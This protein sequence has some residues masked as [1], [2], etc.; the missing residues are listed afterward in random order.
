MIM[1]KR[2]TKTSIVII[3]FVC[4]YV[5][6]IYFFQNK[7]LFEPNTNYKTPQETNTPMFQEN[8]MIVADGTQIMTWYF[9]GDKDKPLLLFFHG[10]SGQI[11]KFTPSL[12]SLTKE[13]YSIAIMEYRGFGNTKGKISQKNTFSDAVEFYN[14]YKSKTE[15][16][17]I[18]YG[19]SF[20]C[21]VAI[22]L[23]QYK[24]PDAIILTAPFTS[25]YQEV[26][27]KFYVPFAYCFIKDKYHSDEYIKNV[28]CPVL[29]IHGKKDMLINHKHSQKLYDLVTIMDKHLVLVDD[30]DHHNIFFKEINNP[31]IIEWL[32]NN[33]KLEQQTN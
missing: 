21:A 27:D 14:Y 4:I 13:G 29:F 20:G 31:I 22:G 1:I 10:N 6:T 23:T 30:I 17:I 9:E 3:L 18:F 32:E 25:F 28:N 7:F 24:T 26:K 5:L 11:A 15:N 33:F 12:V 19:Y 16:K 8:P 2:I